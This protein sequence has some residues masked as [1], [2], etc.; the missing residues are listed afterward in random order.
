MNIDINKY[1]VYNEEITDINLGTQAVRGNNVQVSLSAVTQNNAATVA[2]YK[3]AQL[4][5]D[6]GSYAGSIDQVIPMNLLGPSSIFQYF[7][8]TYKGATDLHYFIFKCNFSEDVWSCDTPLLAADTPIV[9]GFNN[10]EPVAWLNAGKTAFA[11]VLS[12][13]SPVTEFANAKQ[14][15]RI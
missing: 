5:L 7:L 9:G 6:F 4:D 11:V 10:V 15:N 12:Q 1:T 14:I 2:L 8:A 3:N 13:D